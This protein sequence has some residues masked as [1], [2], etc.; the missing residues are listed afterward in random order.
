M[1][2]RLLL[3]ITAA[4]L[5]AS[6]AVFAKPKAKAAHVPPKPHTPSS[7]SPTIKHDEL[8]LGAA[9]TAPAGPAHAVTQLAETLG[10]RYKCT[11]S[12]A[13]AGGG[14]RSTAARMKVTSSLDGYW[15]AFDVD[16][17]ASDAAPFPEKL[18]IVRTYDEGARAWTSVAIDNRGRMATTTADH[19]DEQ[20]VTWLGTSHRDGDRVLVRSH[21]ERDD[22]AGTIRLWSELSRDGST[23][24]KTYDFSCTKIQ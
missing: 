11:G 22:H 10:G 1:K 24:E 6:P 7:V 14:F 18:H 16:E 9:E 4:A 2:P 3:S 21:D 23:Y 17:T 5:L 15:L 12:V 13:N 19:A 20:S 8:G